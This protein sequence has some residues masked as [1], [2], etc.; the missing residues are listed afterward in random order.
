MNA[1]QDV[2]DCINK[3]SVTRAKNMTKD[4]LLNEFIRTILKSNLSIQSV[5]LEVILM[6]QI[7]ALDNILEKPH[8]ERPNEEYQI[9]TMKQALYNSPSVIVSL[10]TEKL[11]KMFY[12]PLTFN[13]IIDRYV[14]IAIF[15]MVLDLLLL[16]F[17]L[18]LLFCSLLLSFNVCFECCI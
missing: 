17:F 3:V 14:L 11:E 8:W 12:S 4:A 16:G 10:L 6:N 1:L 2:Q 15:L 18:P 7:R 5:H 13:I 9:L